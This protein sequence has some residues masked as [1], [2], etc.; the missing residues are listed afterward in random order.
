MMIFV[1][2]PPLL[3]RDMNISV[4]S[5]EMREI[6]MIFVGTYFYRYLYDVS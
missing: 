6:A 5:N 3:G 4:W 2:S 1:G